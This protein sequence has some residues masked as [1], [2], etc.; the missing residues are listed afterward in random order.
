MVLPSHNHGRFISTASR[1]LV[2]RPLRLSYSPFTACDTMAVL[3]LLTQVFFYFAALLGLYSTFFLAFWNGVVAYMERQ[4]SFGYLQSVEGPLSLSYTGI[5]P[6]DI[7]LS[8]LVVFFW[9][10]AEAYS[11]ALTVFWINFAGQLASS[12]T[13]ISL[14]S[15][16]VGN[17]GRWISQYRSISRYFS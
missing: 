8:N 16:R 12:W 10:V 15:V 11:P 17:Q 14:E 9:P 7:M 1:P 4:R 3:N 6:L 13:L 2:L 5:A